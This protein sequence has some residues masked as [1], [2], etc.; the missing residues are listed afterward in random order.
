MQRG[1]IQLCDIGTARRPAIAATT[2]KSFTT[3]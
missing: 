1:L 2:K 3:S